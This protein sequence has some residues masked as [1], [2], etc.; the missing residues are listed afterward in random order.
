MKFS[1]PI[2]IYLISIIQQNIVM[3]QHKII[4]SLSLSTVDCE[5]CPEILPDSIG[6]VV[7]PLSAV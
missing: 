4:L 6:A 7:G 3:I 5:A 2:Q 1:A